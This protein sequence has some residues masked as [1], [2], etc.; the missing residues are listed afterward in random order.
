VRFAHS[1]FRH[2][3]TEAQVRHIVD[4]Y[5]PADIIELESNPDTMGLLYVGD[6]PRGVPL[7]VIGVD[8]ELE[9]GI[10]ELLIIHAMS[11]RPRYQ[12]EYQRIMQERWG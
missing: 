11:L 4:R 10:H 8:I 5:G 3:I 9:G 7:E 12:R 1:A 6:D 2:G